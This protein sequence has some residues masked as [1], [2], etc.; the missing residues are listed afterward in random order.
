L[1]LVANGAGS[2]GA[3]LFL[4]SSIRAGFAGGL[5]PD[6]TRRRLH[7]LM[8]SSSGG[9]GGMW[10]M[11]MKEFRQMRR[12]RRTLAMMILLPV[13][14]LVVFGYA[15]SFDVDR[16]KTV[17][18]G[19]QAEQ[20][21]G[22]LPDRLDV[23]RVAPGEGRQAGVEALR[24]GEA[25]VAVVTGGGQ[26]QVLVD[27]ADLFSARAVVTELRGR[28][29]LPAPEVLFNP[30]LE[31]SAIM[32]PGLM[33]VVL[34]F[35]GTIATAL[36]VVRERQSGTLE[37]LAVM[38][39]RA[40]DVLAGKLLP[41]LGVAV[42]DLAVI[43]AVGVLLFDVPFAGSPLV[44]ALGAIEFLFVT[45]GIGVLISTVS[46]T[47]GQAIQLAIM[48]MLPQILLSGLIFPLQAMAPGVRWIGYL[49]PL[50]WFVQL[51]RGVMVRGAPFE[52]LLLPLG[53]LA[54]LGAVVFGLSIARFRRDLAP[55]GRHRGPDPAAGDQAEAAP[56]RAGAR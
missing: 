3:V 53:M 56:S 38:P 44:F 45:V 13:L 49:L 6:F 1:S 15:A 48:T 27:G 4:H 17:V 31:T 52:A 23:V 34:V 7:P 32:V 11:A 42:V 18:I 33:G 21:A 29:G 40:R 9:A 54:V 16:V 47:Q 14:L 26:P 25:T 39:F 36:G 55:A 22:A 19:P 28:P 12:D 20:V 8:N 43:V 30:G 24:D 5:P 35:V 10:A 51:A 46:E 2:A 41:Y 37:Q 50:T